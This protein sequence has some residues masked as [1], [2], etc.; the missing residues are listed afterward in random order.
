MEKKIA[1]Q[2]QSVKVLKV[3]GLGWILSNWHNMRK[4]KALKSHG[5]AFI[6]VQSKYNQ[7]FIF[8]NLDKIDYIIWIPVVNI[9]FKLCQH[10]RRNIDHTFLNFDTQTLLW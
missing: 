3:W 10:K 4:I 2:K 5:F 1:W 7:N 8:K 9:F 6:F